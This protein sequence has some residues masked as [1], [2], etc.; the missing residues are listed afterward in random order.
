MVTLQPDQPAEGYSD[1]TWVTITAVGDEGYLFSHWSGDLTGSANPASVVMD[2]NKFIAA[3]FVW[4]DARYRL[5]IN[6]APTDSGQITL[7]PSQPAEGYVASKRITV[8]ATASAGYK[9]SHWEGDLTGSTNPA[10]IV[11][12]KNKTITALFLAYC[13]LTVNIDPLGGGT[14]TL[15]PAQPAEGYVEGT[16]VTLTA[17]AAEGY[18]F[19]HWSGALSGSENPTTITIGS[20]E[21]V[22]AN[23]AKVG[24]LPF[25]WWW[26]LV[27]GGVI[28]G[29]PLF[30][31]IIGRLL[32]V[33]TSGSKEE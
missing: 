4:T 9:F 31:L 12:D 3:N 18:K 6:V 33:A 26:L 17:T 20:D 15:E 10:L 30:F 2:K 24:R 25:P 13:V 11:M 8:T 14:F 7:V 29:I 1:G 32:V 19:D 28:I 23:F 27:G 5:A 22:R 16:I 21:E